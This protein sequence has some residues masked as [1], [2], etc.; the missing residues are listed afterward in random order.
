MGHFGP[1]PLTKPDYEI[2]WEGPLPYFPFESLFTDWIIFYRAYLL[3][4]MES[5][6]A[7]RDFA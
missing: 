6:H 4:D 5:L 3:A 2:Q 7:S 1:S